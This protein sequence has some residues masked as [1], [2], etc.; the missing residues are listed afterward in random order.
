MKQLGDKRL[1]ETNAGQVSVEVLPSYSERMAFAEEA[2]ENLGIE[3][4]FEVLVGDSRFVL[5]IDTTGMKQEEEVTQKVRELCDEFDEKYFNLIEIEGV[6]DSTEE[7]M[8]KR[9]ASAARYIRD[10]LDNNRKYLKAYGEA[11]RIFAKA[12]GKD[13]NFQ[14]VYYYRGV[15]FGWKEIAQITS[16]SQ[17]IKAYLDTLDLTMKTKFKNE[18]VEINKRK[19]NNLKIR[20]K[21]DNVDY[22]EFEDPSQAYEDK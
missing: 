6:D 9:I 11:K 13:G 16:P 12:S 2:M 18:I 19:N 20:M 5:D 7:S 17:Q 21:L 22:F 4:N 3:L 1:Y 8:V 15:A 10:I 14:R